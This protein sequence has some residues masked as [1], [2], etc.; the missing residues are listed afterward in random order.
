MKLP[1]VSASVVAAI[2]LAAPTHADPIGADTNFVAMLD[3]AGITY[4][5][6]ESVI[7]AGKE[8]CELMNTGQT[9]VDVVKKLTDKNPGFTISGAARFAA[10]AAN[11]YCPQRLAGGTGGDG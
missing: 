2:G 9:D 3:D 8:V 11:A 10:I 4:D 1:A 7:V 5:N 6:T